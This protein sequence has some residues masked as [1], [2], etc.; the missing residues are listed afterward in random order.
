MFAF[1]VSIGEPVGP[2]WFLKALKKKL[3]FWKPEE[4]SSSQVVLWMLFLY[5]REKKQ[6]KKLSVHSL[7]A[8]S[9]SPHD[10]FFPIRAAAMI[11]DHETAQTEMGQSA[12][13]IPADA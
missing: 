2:V 7:T 12:E 4:T 9:I 1:W 10:D 8:N 11:R 13:L 6:T 3:R 5:L